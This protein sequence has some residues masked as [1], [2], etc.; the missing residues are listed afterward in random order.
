YRH[1]VRVLAVFACTLLGLAASAPAAFAMRVQDLGGSADLSQ[2]GHSPGSSNTVV[3]GG[4]AGWQIA[5][6]VVVAALLAATI[7]VIVLRVRA[8][9][10]V[11]PA[12]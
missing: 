11:V 12:A 5:V 6:I 10:Q 8:A 2:V 1:T 7:A 3:A 9:H 4:M